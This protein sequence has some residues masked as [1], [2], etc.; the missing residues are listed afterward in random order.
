M[1]TQ[2]CDVIRD[3]GMGAAEGV[4]AAS[5][6]LTAAAGVLAAAGIEAAAQ[7]PR[8]YNQR[9]QARTGAKSPPPSNYASHT[10]PVL[11]E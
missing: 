5:I 10:V 3:A 8:G 9:P 11:P 1:S 6:R 4:T 2:P 7:W